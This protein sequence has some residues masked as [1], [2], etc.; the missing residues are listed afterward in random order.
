VSDRGDESLDVVV[1][2]AGGGVAEV[3]GDSVGEAGRQERTRRFPP[4][5]GSSPLPRAVNAASQSMAAIV[6][7]LLVTCSMKQ[8]AAVRER[9]AAY[10][11]GKL[12][13]RG[14]AG[15][16][17]EVPR[18]VRQLSWR[19][20]AFCFGSAVPGM[21]RSTVRAEGSQAAAVR[22]S[23]PSWGG[24]TSAVFP[25]MSMQMTFKP[26]LLPVEPG[27]GGDAGFL[28]AANRERFGPCQA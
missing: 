7:P 26:D 23:A 2:E 3:D 27:R 6:T 11:Q 13:S 12:A 18:P 15:G 21:P 14:R 10:E 4:E 24:S 16:R 17:F 28:P 1:V 22:P 25:W 19:V 5:Q 8:P 20:L 9:A